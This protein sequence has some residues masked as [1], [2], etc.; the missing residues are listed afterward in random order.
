[1]S[2]RLLESPQ[3][4]LS[5]LTNAARDAQVDGRLRVLEAGCGKRWRLRPDGVS[6]HIT[7]VDLDSTALA[8]R[9]ERE[10]DLD[11]EIIADLRSVPLP[12]EAFDL[13]YCSY[14][15]EH[16]AGAQQV[17]DRFVTALRPGGRLIVRVPDGDSVYGFL[18]KHSPHRA[19]VLYKRYVE[20]K[21][22][23]GKPGYAPYPTVYDPVVSAH[24]LR[25]W[26]LDR[27]L[28]IADAYGTNFY[29]NAFGRLGRL[30]DLLL[31]SVAKASRGRLSATH[32]NIGF[33]FVKP[34]MR[35]SNEA[36]PAAA[37]N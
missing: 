26:A 27:G 19:H 21:P 15:L 2:I 29:L 16:V 35:D 32:N 13:V 18:T 37:A 12:A 36:H 1:L 34:A 9:R 14:V 22:N 23:A 25:S 8:I 4:E 24:G 33:V 11:A 31:R 10:G 20:G 7:G 6:I 5:L 30:V 17:L 28:Q 3:A